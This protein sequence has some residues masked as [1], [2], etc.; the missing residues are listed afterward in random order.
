MLS[1]PGALDMIHSVD[2]VGYLLDVDNVPA[3]VVIS[4]DDCDIIWSI[5]LHKQPEVR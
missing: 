1:L 5:D 2:I 4:V 3:F